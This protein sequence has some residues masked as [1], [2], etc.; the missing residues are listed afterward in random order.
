MRQRL[1]ELPGGFE[2]EVNMTAHAHRRPAQLA[3]LL[4][5]LALLSACANSG[6]PTLTSRPAAATFITEAEIASSHATTAYQ[7]IELSHPVFLLSAV[8]LGPLR[9]REV[10]LNGMRLGGINELRGIPASSVREIRFVRAIDAGASG[11]VRPGGAILVFSK[12]GR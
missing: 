1:S 6:Q 9:E 4:G 5:G 7:A 3:F 8:D 2:P 10:Y 11:M 12:A